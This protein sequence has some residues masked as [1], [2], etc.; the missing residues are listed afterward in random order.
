MTTI[1]TEGA[2]LPWTD[3]AFVADPYPFYAAVQ[4]THPVYREDERTFIVS[5]YADVMRSIRLPSM[6]TANA[7]WV[8]KDPWDAWEHTALLLE[9]PEHTRMR[10]HTNRWFTPKLVTQWVEVTR[11]HAMKA[12]DGV[13][14]DGLIEAHMNLGVL[15]PHAT[16]CHVLGLPDAYSVAVG[17]AMTS[18]MIA[19]GF[20]H[21][22]EQLDAAERGFAFMHDEVERM[23]AAKRAEPGDSLVDA[24]LAAEAAGEITE[25][26][27]LETVTL[28]YA[29]GSPNSAYLI[30][31]GLVLF[32]DRPDLLALYR[33]QP[34]IRS[35][36][37]NELV[38]LNPVELSVTRFAREDVEIGGVH[39]PADSKI[40]FMLAAANR[41]P[42]IFD[43]PDEFDH[44]RSGEASRNL[45]FGTG[46]HACAGQVIAR[47]ETETV[48][49]AVAESVSHV[50]LV[51][52]PRVG[53][54]ERF[55]TYEEL[56]LRL[57]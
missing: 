1:T 32:A 25:R 34:D 16:M 41:D 33:D 40:Q 19:I 57:S 7:S 10:R 49:S 11:A 17:E 6:Q 20:V 39:V 5:R 29:Q 54:T 52:E 21:T 48:L 42:E 51:G 31:S 36:F 13:G 22:E 47:A 45:S 44:T 27:V 28:F 8:G 37:V 53:H 43:R 23:I 50:E 26:E 12:L 18:A 9:P 24:L 3:P 35:A 30:D 55:R 4:R 56:Q 2:S 38:R 14:S 46:V 15:P